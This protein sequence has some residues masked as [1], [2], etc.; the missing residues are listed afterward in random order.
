MK[1]NLLK[2]KM[3][4]SHFFTMLAAV[5]IAIVLFSASLS[6]FFKS[7][8]PQLDTF[9]FSM[10]NQ[11]KFDDSFRGTNASSNITFAIF[12]SFKCTACIEQYPAIRQLMLD[13]PEVNFLFKHVVSSNNLDEVHAA[14]SFECAKKQQHGYD[15]AEFMLTSQFKQ[16]DITSFLENISLNMPLFYLC[17][18]NESTLAMLQADL[19]HASFLD[20][21]GTPTIFL[22]GIKIEGVHSYEIYDEMIKREKRSN[23]LDYK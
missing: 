3:K 8:T 9:N 14:K 2:T 21:K 5:L 22:N 1:G 4:D 11:L 13:Y 10:H 20:V 15:L 12:L 23:T 16:I 7:P 6:V 17:M 18:E 19:Y